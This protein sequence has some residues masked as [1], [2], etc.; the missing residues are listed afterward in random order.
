MLLCENK[1]G[2]CQLTFKKKMFQNCRYWNF[3]T[4]NTSQ[5]NGGISIWTPFQSTWK[6]LWLQIDQIPNECVC[7]DVDI[8][9]SLW[10][11]RKL[12]SDILIENLLRCKMRSDGLMRQ[13][14]VI[15]KEIAWK[16]RLALLFY[17]VQDSH[18]ASQ[19]LFDN[20]RC[21]F[22]SALLARTLWFQ[23]LCSHHHYAQW[24]C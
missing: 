6:R 3:I 18:L 2:S 15:F 8:L 24:R 4:Y 16:S 17:L 7:Y 13:L 9:R 23:V 19:H 21:S 11:Q 5:V 12:K 14:N 1:L 20:I 22:Q 10:N